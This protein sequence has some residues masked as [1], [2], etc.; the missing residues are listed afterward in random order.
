MTAR[1]GFTLVEVL[2]ALVILELG[3]MAVAGTLLTASRTL[4]RAEVQEE[5]A[6]AVTRVADS[7]VQGVDG[8]AGKT[9]TPRGVVQWWAA[10][11]GAFHVEF[12][13]PSDSA[14]VV[15]DGRGSP[16]P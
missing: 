15:V 13:T 1:T 3:L 9:A 2:V 7:L 10:G 12:S 5:G 14:L 8:G 16:R 4:A 6:E 11:G